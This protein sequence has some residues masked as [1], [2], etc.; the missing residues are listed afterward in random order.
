MIINHRKKSLSIQKSIV[1]FLVTFFLI[2]GSLATCSRQLKPER[3]WYELC[4]NRDLVLSEEHKNTRVKNEGEF[5]MFPRLTSR[6]VVDRA[7]PTPKPAAFGVGYFRAL[8]PTL[9]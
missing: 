1:P 7:Y 2:R 5:W 3:V 4:R 9:P 6:N 8:P